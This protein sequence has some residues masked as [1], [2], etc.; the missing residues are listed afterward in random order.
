MSGGRGEQLG[1]LPRW[2]RR[3]NRSSA[4]LRRRRAPGAAEELGAEIR[5]SRARTAALRR[6][7]PL[8]LLA[9]LALLAPSVSAQTPGEVRVLA[10]DGMINPVSE[11]YLVRG[12]DDAADEGAGLVLIELDTPGGLLD[13]TQQLTGAMLASDVPIAVYVTPQGSRAASAGVFVTMAAHVAAMAPNTRIGAATPVSGDGSEIPEDLR[14]KLVN[15]T[16]AYARSIATARDRNADWAEDAVR[17]A[18]V[19]DAAEALELDVIDLVAADRAALL[20]ELDGRAVALPAGETTL[21]TS[22]VPVVERPMSPFEQLFMALADPNIA[23]LL[24]S[25]GGIGIYFELAN[26]GAML[27]GIVG[28]IFL[29]LAFLSLGTLPLSYAGLAF[30]ILGLVL[31]GAEVFVASGGLLGVGGVVAFGLGALLFIDER[32]AP[33][34]E[35]SRP[36]ILVLTAGMGAFVLVALRGMAQ[37]RRKPAAMGSD[38]LVGRIASVR[39]PSEVFVLGELWQARPATTDQEALVPGT[40]ARIVG[41]SGL[42]LL[43][44]PVSQPSPDFEHGPI[45]PGH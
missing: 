11:R 6:L 22:G 24:L 14:N 43:V 18:V 45:A 36:L 32:Q 44:E 5:R 35:V 4:A 39:T 2:V 17:D 13:A 31:M 28:A 10:L 34:V 15:D 21:G 9:G 33:F 3:A 25:L 19:V 1:R 29:I 26:P 42:V 38:E 16:V 27:P 37:V 40:T 20:E 7:G 23:L 8:F 30:V 41:R 12:I